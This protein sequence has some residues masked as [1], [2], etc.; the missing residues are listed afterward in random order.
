MYTDD[1]KGLPDKPIVAPTVFECAVMFSDRLSASGLTY[2]ASVLESIVADFKARRADGIDIVA[3]VGD[4]PKDFGLNIDMMRVAAHVPSLWLHEG[5][6]RASLETL[7]TTAGH[8]LN[9]ELARAKYDVASIRVFP[10]GQLRAV[11]AR[12][13]EYNLSHF[14]ITAANSIAFKSEAL[15]DRVKA[16]NQE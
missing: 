8:L 10:I 6:L 5:A 3:V 13:T 16:F 4:E 1:M 9:L 14:G 12:V 7:D 15:G 2:P 11:D